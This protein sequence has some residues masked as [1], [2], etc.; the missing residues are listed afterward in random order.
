MCGFVGFTGGAFEKAPVLSRMTA[1]IAHRGPD[2]EGFYTDERV[3]LGFRRLSIQDL[4]REGDQPFADESGRYRMV[5][6][7]E[8]YNFPALREELKALGHT[9]RTGT[10]TEVLLHGYLEYGEA[11]L[12]R[13]RGMFAFVIYDSKDGSLFGASDFFGIKPF[14]YT[15][16]SDG[17]FGFASE[18]KSLL[19]HPLFVREV[20]REA[21]R[22]SLTLQYSATEETFFRGVFKL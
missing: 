8:I 18:I 16:F 6:N 15:V 5:F 13:L 22:P 1:R 12:D 7:G 21:L 10:D 20:N 2:S 14:Y 19:E 17:T 9:F 11:C 3:A 4:S